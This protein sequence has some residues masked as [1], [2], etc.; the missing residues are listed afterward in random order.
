MRSFWILVLLLFSLPA[1]SQEE[2]KNP[3]RFNYKGFIDS[4]QAART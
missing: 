1:F 2:E 4:Y 3:F